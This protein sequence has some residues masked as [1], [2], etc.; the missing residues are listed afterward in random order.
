MIKKLFSLSI[1]LFF[2]FV[3]AQSQTLTGTVKD[4]NTGETLIMVNVLGPNRQ[5]TVTN[6]KGEFILPLTAGTSKIQISYIGYDAQEMEVSLKNG[7]T[8]NIDISLI[9]RNEVLET[10]VISA[11]KFEQRIEET[12][13]SLEVIKPNLVE[14]KNIIALQDAFNQVPGVIVTDD[15]ANIRSGSGWSF[16]A[17]SRVLMMVDDMPLMSPDAGQ[18]QWK[19]LPNEAIYQMEVIKGAASALFGTGAM[20]GLINVRTA[21]PKQEPF[22]EVVL[23]G[24][25][26]DAP[27]RKSLK[28]WTSPQAIGG[29]T[30]LHSRKIGTTDFTISGIFTRD[31]GFRWQETDDR[32]RINVKTQFYPKRVKGLTWG[33]NASAL[34]SESGDA[35][36]WWDYENAYIPRDSSSAL[37]SGWDYYI[38]PF[39]MFRHGR[40]KH[41][42]RGRYLGINNDVA[43]ESTNY[44]NNSTYYYAEYQYQHFLSDDLWITAGMVGALAYSQSAVFDGY[45]ESENGAFFAQVDKTFKRLSISG[46]FRYEAFKLDD[47]NFSK[48]VL[49]A[50]ANYKIAKATFLR[51]SYGGGYRFPSMAEVFTKTNVGSTGVY[52][53]YELLPE[54]GWTAEIGLKQGFQVS[55]TWKGFLDIAAFINHFDNMTEFSFGFW[56]SS[57]NPFDNLGFKSVNVGATEIRGLEA[58]ITSQGKIGPVGLRLLTGYSFMNPVSLAPD[59]VYANYKLAGGK[60]EDV[61]YESTSSDPTNNIL[62]YRYKHLFRFDVQFEYKKIGLGTSIKYNDYMQNID[63]IF[64]ESLGNFELF[65]G[66]KESRQNFKSGDLIFDARAYYDITKNWRVSFIV[67]NLTN[68]EVVSRPSQLGPPRK[69]TVQVKFSI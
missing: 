50:G 63:K 43:N 25:A 28:W 57:P 44:A 11:G 23:Y 12:T 34:Y 59:L 6:N 33:V 10:V 56:G 27:K 42:L 7:E 51:A 29:L 31:Q 17:G 55:D 62:K 14:E 66:V 38:D 46:G 3:T 5:G 1:L 58:T 21:I 30:F 60:T 41:T 24:G 37:A 47:R 18:I 4:A 49:R 45:H 68:R 16:G 61:S 64:E 69:Y 19:L 40:G 35:L 67:D 39:V 8:K 32:N 2:C 22:T 53:N 65:P 20:N 36:L 48:P 54:S 52:P 26:Y 15:Q 9:P 13:V